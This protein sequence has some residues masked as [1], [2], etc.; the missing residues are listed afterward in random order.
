MPL[1]ASDHSPVMAYLM[2]LLWQTRLELLKQL[3]LQT[4]RKT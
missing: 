3:R 1:S 4:R 2:H